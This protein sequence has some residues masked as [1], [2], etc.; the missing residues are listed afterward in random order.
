LPTEPRTSAAI[1]G[2]ILGALLSPLAA[3]APARADGNG[4]LPAAFARLEGTRYVPSEDD[5][6]WDAWVGGGV[7][8]LKAGNVTVEFTADVETILGREIRTFDPN[9]ANYHLAGAL[10]IVV[11]GD[12]VIPFF[13]HVSRHEI[14]RPKTQAVDWNLM[15]VR[16]RATFAEGR[17]WVVVGIGHTLGDTPVDY[18]WELTGRAELEP[19]RPFYVAADIRWVNAEPVPTFPRGSFTDLSLEGGA[20]WRRGQH[21]LDLF[22]AYERRND[23]FVQAPGMRERLLLGFRI[24][25]AGRTR[26]PR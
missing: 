2:V 14:D 20:R 11:G 15:G 1:R 17:A 13:H 3:A 18:G 8:V 24:G 9:Q 23:I 19:L 5:Q 16:A 25:P 6:V 26:A 4:F 12:E 22:A 21:D 10:R 7:D